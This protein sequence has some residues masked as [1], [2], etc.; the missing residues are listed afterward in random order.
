VYSLVSEADDCRTGDVGEASL[1]TVTGGELD[2][3][4]DKQTGRVISTSA[5]DVEGEEVN[6][7]A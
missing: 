3:R 4:K 6:E 1:A 7:R 2:D 5:A